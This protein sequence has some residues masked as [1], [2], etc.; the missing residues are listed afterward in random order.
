MYLLTV[1]C[2]RLILNVDFRF[3]SAILCLLDDF[4]SRLTSALAR[5]PTLSV[6]VEMTFVYEEAVEVVAA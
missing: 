6:T 1:A 5:L 4:K 3:V 2:F